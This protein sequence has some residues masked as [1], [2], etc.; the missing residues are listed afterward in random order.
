MGIIT[1]TIKGRKYYYLEHSYRIKNKVEKKVEYLGSEIP[2]NIEKI[3]ANF[4]GKINQI[5]WFDDLNKI[6]KNFSKEFKSLPKLARKKLL[7]I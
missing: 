3:K 1:R 4:I 6:K 7:P 2:K 5:A